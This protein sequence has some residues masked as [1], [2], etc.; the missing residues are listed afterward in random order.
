MSCSCELNERL[1]VVV[2][3]AVSCVCSVQCE[4]FTPCCCAHIQTADSVEE[5]SVPLGAV[6]QHFASFS[7]HVRRRQRAAMGGEIGEWA[8]A[9]IYSA[10]TH[11]TRS[12]QF[13]AW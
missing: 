10:S 11:V 4:Y 8:T 3:N 7:S 6:C 5:W 12:I 9:A 1:C 13:S 2:R